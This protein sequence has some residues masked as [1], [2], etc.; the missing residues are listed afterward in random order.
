[1]NACKNIS[2]TNLNIVGALFLI[3]LLKNI[4]LQIDK[5]PKQFFIFS[6]AMRRALMIA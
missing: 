6:L 5:G 3:F 4:I 2:S 1:M